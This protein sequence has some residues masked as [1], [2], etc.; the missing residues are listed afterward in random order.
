MKLAAYAFVALFSASIL[1]LGWVAPANAEGNCTFGHS[2]KT[3]QSAS[4]EVAQTKPLQ[5][6]K[7]TNN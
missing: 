2:V 3:A 4:Q 7:P 5:T 6:P 1:T